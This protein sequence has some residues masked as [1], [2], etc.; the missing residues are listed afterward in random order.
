MYL[1]ENAAGVV[2]Q[3]GD[4]ADALGHTRQPVV[5]QP[6]AI[7]HHVVDMAAGGGHIGV[8]FRQNVILGGHKC[9]RHGQQ[10]AILGRLVQ[11]G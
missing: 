5:I 2:G 4:G 11:R 8:V 1:R 9:L 6:Q 7:Q 3:G 10:A